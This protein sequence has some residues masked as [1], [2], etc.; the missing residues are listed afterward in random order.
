MV[1]GL[2]KRAGAAGT[3]M[4][5]AAL[6]ALAACSKE[7][8]E[9][10]GFGVNVV[11]DARGLTPEVRGRI[12]KGRLTAHDGAA[13]FSKTFDVKSAISG[14]E[15][16]FRYV[17]NLTAGALGLRFEGLDASDQP[18][19][20][21]DSGT[22][23]LDATRAVTARITLAAGSPPAADGGVDAPAVD[24]PTVDAPV[25]DM[26]TK[27]ANGQACTA[28]TAG[29]CAS[30][31]C[32]DGVCCNSACTGVCESCVAGARG[33]CEPV[34]DNVNPDNECLPPPPPDAGAP[35]GDGGVPADG[36]IVTPDGGI[37]A[38][39]AACRGTC[40][41]RRACKFPGS[42]SSCGSTWCTSMTEVA[43]LVCDGKGSC[44]PTVAGC[45]AYACGAGACKTQCAGHDDCQ[46]GKTYCTASNVCAPKKDKGVACG[47][48]LEC[49]TGHCAGGVCCNSA[50]DS[51][52]TCTETPVGSCKCPG[53]TCPQGVACQVYYRDADA[54]TFGDKFGTIANGAARA[55]CAGAPP[56]GFVANNTDC[57]DGD[58]N[59]KPGQLGF[60]DVP[61]VSR[62]TYDY[63]CDGVLAKETPDALG[64]TCKFCKGGASLFSCGEPGYTCTAD[65]QRAGLGCG[66][67]CGTGAFRFCF[68]GPY[69]GFIGAVDC[70]I[71]GDY[72]VCGTCTLAGQGPSNSYMY[73]KKQACH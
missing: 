18:A 14:G 21:G 43:R 40:N 37:T 15:L 46:A 10:T 71:P 16:R 32:A 53:V 68:C 69:D 2:G 48:G 49:Q 13:P 36:G 67:T 51:P 47:T 62:R 7:T 35:V 41:G 57:D 11:V 61:S 56:L 70:G 59:A 44:G 6:V 38:N 9:P 45:T 58:G 3:A 25:A 54:D 4:V 17:P 39:E 23:T 72:K 63:N 5:M 50:C 33:T 27:K 34:A 19:A 64:A 66:I 29:E 20:W 30:G 60:F 28:A 31:I 24:A 8:S 42:E 1:A 55:A 12:E 22:V 73:K 52:F 65:G 26:S